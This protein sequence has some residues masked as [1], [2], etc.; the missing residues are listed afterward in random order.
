MTSCAVC[1]VSGYALLPPAGHPNQDRQ[2]AYVNGRPVQCE[3]LQ[4]AVD[5]LYEVALKHSLQLADS[6]AVGR[7]ADRGELRVLRRVSSQ[8]AAFVLELNCEPG[9]AQLLRSGGFPTAVFSAQQLVVAACKR[10]A[11][12]AWAPVLP[13]ALLRQVEP[14]A[15]G[16]GPAA[17][18]AGEDIVQLPAWLQQ[19]APAPAPREAAARQPQSWPRDRSRRAPALPGQPSQTRR[20][21]GRSAASGSAQ[22]RLLG[23]KHAT[24]S[25]APCFSGMPTAGAPAPGSG[26]AGSASDA[27]VPPAKRPRLGA[28]GQP[29][30]SRSHSM[31]SL[32]QSW[33]ATKP[34]AGY[35]ALPAAAP[36]KQADPPRAPGRQGGL[37]AKAPARGSGPAALAS[38]APEGRQSIDGLLAGWANPSLRPAPVEHV[39]QLRD[40]QLLATSL[41]A[42]RELTGLQLQS[43]RALRQLDAKFVPIVCGHVVAVVDQHAAG[44][45]RA[46]THDFCACKCRRLPQGPVVCSSVARRPGG[47]Y[48][49]PPPARLPGADERVQLELLRDCL[50]AGGAGGGVLDSMDVEQALSLAPTE[51]S[52]LELYVGQLQSWGWR[53]RQGGPPADSSAAC[54]LTSVPL[55]LGTALTS[56]DMLVRPLGADQQPRRVRSAAR[57]HR[58]AAPKLLAVHAPRAAVRPPAPRDVRRRRAAARRCARLELQGVPWGHHVWRHADGRAGE[59]VRLWARR[60]SA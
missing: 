57:Q 7:P 5:R 45:P 4:E 6:V 47:S 17:F 54:T 2:L 20:S 1:T 55:V 38:A 16:S 8:H 29:T 28:G 33:T 13:N 10:A 21:A 26:P 15:V 18:G 31:G 39:L 36:F 3:V 35:T 14:L 52:L 32:R 9:S 46:R 43:A 48:P 44:M 51:C 24:S 11:L 22:A 23:I 53:W 40:V 12:L 49:P 50:L 25:V 30:G 42:P 56:V 19:E 41:I 59:R 58:L 37:P 34:K 27:R 60:Q